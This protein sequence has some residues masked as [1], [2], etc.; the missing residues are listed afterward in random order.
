MS[1]LFL[2]LAIAGGLLA[3]A[4]LLLARGRDLV[5]LAVLLLALALA[6]WRLG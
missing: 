6:V 3:V 1:G 5:A 2:G 4:Q